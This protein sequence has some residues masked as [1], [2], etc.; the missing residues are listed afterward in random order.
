MKKPPPFTEA[1]ERAICER[2]G[3]S[4]T[5]GETIR[6]IGK[7]IGSTDMPIRA[8]LVKHGIE[9]RRTHGRAGSGGKDLCDVPAK[10]FPALDWRLSP[11]ERAERQ[12]GGKPRVGR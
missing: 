2:Y 11:Q 8:V 3:T 12:R 10:T 6:Q 7:D 9:L 4:D 5:P 1:Q